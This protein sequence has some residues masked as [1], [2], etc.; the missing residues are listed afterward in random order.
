MGIN[1]SAEM[2]A[3]AIANQFATLPEVTAVALAG[4]RT[5]P[6]SDTLSDVELYRYEHSEVTVPKRNLLAHKYPQKPQ[7]Y[8]LFWEDGDEWIDEATGLAVDIT[9]RSPQWIEEQLDRV[10]VHHQASLGYSTCFWANVRTS[11]ALF[12][13]EGWFARLQQ[14]ADQ[15]YSDELQQAIIDKNYPVLRTL[16]HSA[17]VRQLESAVKRGD[18]V[19]V[20]HRSA[21]ILASYFDI[22]FAVN[23]QLHPGEKR[24][25][26]YAQQL[27]KVPADCAKDVDAFIVSVCS[28]DTVLSAATRLL[29]KLDAL[30]AQE[31]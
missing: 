25:V 2:I 31:R 8:M 11:K 15:P 13:R 26:Q 6:D 3:Q 1:L 4:S 28:P 18:L 23:K 30:L 10:L 16:D 19:S 12:D 17:Y 22:L 24:L 9:Y 21:A 14:I 29:D 20:Q 7:I 27:A 5:A